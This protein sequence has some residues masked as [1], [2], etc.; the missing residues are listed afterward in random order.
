MR[1]RALT[2]V[3]AAVA[4]LVFGASPAL[5]KGRKPPKVWNGSYT[6]VNYHPPSVGL[7][8]SWSG[9]VRFE[10][11]N[12][13]RK[14]RIYNYGGTGS[15]TYTFSGGNL[16]S[17]SGAQTLSTSGD[18]AA[19]TVYRNRSGWKYFLEIGTREETITAQEQCPEQAVEE[20]DF[21]PPYPLMTGRKDRSSPVDWA[22]SPATTTKRTPT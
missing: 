15:V 17:Y 12:T 6:G 9:S 8:T 5:G 21:L 4:L 19:L 13:N 20:L 16:C 3:V 2:V 11:L 18:D 7:V 10:L 14:R 22:R 1:G